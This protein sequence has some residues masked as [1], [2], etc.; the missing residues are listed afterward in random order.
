MISDQGEWWKIGVDAWL[1]HAE[2]QAALNTAIELERR[3]RMEIGGN[4]GTTD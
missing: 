4:I 2:A 1:T 3:R